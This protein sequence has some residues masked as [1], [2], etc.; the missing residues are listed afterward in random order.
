MP[1]KEK[2][3]S[4]QAD[5]AVGLIET[6]GFTA[7]FEAIDTALKAADVAGI[8]HCACLTNLPFLQ[9]KPAGLDVNAGSTPRWCLSQP[10]GKRLHGDSRIGHADSVHAEPG[11]RSRGHHLHLWRCSRSTGAYVHNINI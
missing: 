7:V 11:L 4:Q 9:Q 10:V 3:V 2:T 1:K 6:Q 8:A 5:F